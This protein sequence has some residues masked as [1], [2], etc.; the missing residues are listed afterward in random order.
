MYKSEHLFIN[1]LEGTDVYVCRQASIF[2]FP[3][4][5]LALGARF[6]SGSCVPHLESELG[7]LLLKHLSIYS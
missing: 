4:K 6:L 2:L 5:N 1:V 7:E 3:Q